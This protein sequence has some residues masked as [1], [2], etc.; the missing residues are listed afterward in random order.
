MDY[1]EI[2]YQMALLEAEGVGATIARQV[3]R[4]FWVS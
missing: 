3:V 1:E 2:Q 4:A